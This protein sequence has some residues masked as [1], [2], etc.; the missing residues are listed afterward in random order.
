MA[1][2]MGEFDEGESWLRRA[3]EVAEADVDPAAAVL[4]HV[5]NGM[6]HAARAQ[7]QAAVEEFGAAARAQ[8]RLRGMHVLAP[9]ITGWLAASRARLG[10]LDEARA[11]LAGFSA[12][13]SGSVP[14]TTV[15]WAPSTTLAQ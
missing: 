6:L 15:E 9:R 11:T 13:P 1:I 4:L 2:W 7:H 5:A 3:R 8:S 12:D 14:F 10:M